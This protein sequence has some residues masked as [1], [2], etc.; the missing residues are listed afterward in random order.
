[1]RGGELQ[2]RTQGQWWQRCPTG[3]RREIHLGD[4]VSSR[5]FVEGYSGFCHTCSENANVWSKECDEDESRQGN[6]CTK[7]NSLWSIPGD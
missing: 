4:L 6:K 2:M 3:Y 7:Q 5:V 1:M